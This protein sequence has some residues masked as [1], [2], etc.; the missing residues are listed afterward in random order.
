MPWY[1][2]VVEVLGGS[3]LAG[4]DDHLEPGSVYYLLFLEVTG[5]EKFPTTKGGFSFTLSGL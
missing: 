5:K 4:V 3:R 1:L 2:C